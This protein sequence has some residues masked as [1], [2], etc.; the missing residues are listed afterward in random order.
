M[1]FDLTAA[2][3]SSSST[4]GWTFSENLIGSGAA[5]AEEP[6]A[7]GE[8]QVSATGELQLQMAADGGSCRGGRQRIVVAAVEADRRWW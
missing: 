4:G 8:L 1:D 5:C 6:A 3:G 2:G 7:D